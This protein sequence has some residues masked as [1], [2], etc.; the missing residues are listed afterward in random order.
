MKG[1]YFSFD[2]IIGGVI[3]ILTAMA[4]F[5][6][7]YGISGTLDQRHDML[8]KEAFRV[9]E[10]IYTPVDPGLSVGW[11]DQHINY[12]KFNGG[13]CQWMMAPQEA[14][15]SGYGI[16]IYFYEIKS[17]PQ[18]EVSELD[19]CRWGT[20]EYA[21]SENVYRFRRTASYLYEDGNTTLG[22]MDIVVYEPVQI[23]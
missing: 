4:L 15:G 7:W 1:Q 8:A 12:S 17:D 5:S 6:Y 2:A 13:H 23:Q 10:M 19:G 20:E 3:F 18:G 22:Y 14:F 16:T 9:S 21:S 11:R